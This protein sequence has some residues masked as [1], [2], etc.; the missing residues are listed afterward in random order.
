MPEPVYAPRPVP[1]APPP[2]S[3]PDQGYRQPQYRQPHYQSS[4]A[5]PQYAEPDYDETGYDEAETYGEEPEVAPLRLPSLGGLANIA[6]G[7]LSLGLIGAVAI[8]GYNV[9][10]RDVS[11]IPVVRALE[12]TMREAPEEPG[13]QPMDH[14]GLAVNS[15]A[16]EGIAAPT[17]DRLVL[18]PPPTS[19][20]DEDLPTAELT[21]AV[22]AATAPP[23]PVVEPEPVE[24][25]QAQAIDMV[26]AELT[27]V[28]PPEPE[29]AVA[30]AADVS[31]FKVVPAAVPGIA[32]SVRPRVRPATLVTGEA[33]SGPTAIDAALASAGP[34]DVAASAI[35]PGTRLV[36]LGAFESP[37]VA[38]AE[39][40]RLNA[41]YGDYL[42]GKGRVIQK[43]ES[44]GRTFYRLRAMGFD[45]LSAARRFCSAM[46]AE[47]AACIPV[48]AR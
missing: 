1:P 47:G 20:T 8:W 11:G 37:E 38:R 32:N 34:V 25:T 10:T 22:D 27:G 9:M 28:T 48:T 31:D 21:A 14:Q 18:A 15:V 29:N 46:V 4:Y 30:D 12:G 23:P 26:V 33:T 45:D 36:Q 40:D 41:R 17:A 43:A 24:I 39:W 16:A 42:E 5:E 3:E 2:Y 6:G 19:L 13:G 44:G 35:T 7:M